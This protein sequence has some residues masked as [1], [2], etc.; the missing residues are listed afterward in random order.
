MIRRPPRSTLFPYTT[1]FRSGL[2]NLIA[3]Q[4]VAPEFLQGAVTPQ[5]LAETVLPLLDPAGAAA[6][7]PRQGLALVR[8]RLWPPGGAGPVAALAGGAGRGRGGVGRG[9]GWGKRGDLGGGGS[10]KKKKE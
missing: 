2:V 6:R 3:G 4:E 10:I 1:L 8:D 5:A 9:A 7:R